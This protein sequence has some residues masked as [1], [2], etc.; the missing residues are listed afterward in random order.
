MATV[1]GEMTKKGIE[2]V[3]EDPEVQRALYHRAILD[4]NEAFDR[5]ITDISDENYLKLAEI[6]RHI[7]AEDLE[8]QKQGPEFKTKFLQEVNASLA[9]KGINAEDILE[10]T[11]R[12]LKMHRDEV[13]RENEMEKEKM[14]PEPAV[15]VEK[16]KGMFGKWFR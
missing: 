15:E 13:T 5:Y 11:N 16:P 4:L 9:E 7:M 14:A 12:L 2:A 8:I 1:T 3:G 6:R 10:K